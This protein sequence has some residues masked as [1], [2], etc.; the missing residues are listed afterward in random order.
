MT[1]DVSIKFTNYRG[2]EKGTVDTHGGAMALFS[3][4]RVATD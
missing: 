4:K 2:K 3:T 1:N